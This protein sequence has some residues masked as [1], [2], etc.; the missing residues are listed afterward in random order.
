MDQMFFWTPK[1]VEEVMIQLISHK[2]DI[3]YHYLYYAITIG[4]YVHSTQ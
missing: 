3:N 1:L 4:S 2:T